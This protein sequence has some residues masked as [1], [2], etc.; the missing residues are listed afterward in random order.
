MVRVIVNANNI[1]IWRRVKVIVSYSFYRL[2][3][4]LQTYFN[5]LH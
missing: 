4:F 2:H 5:I 1:V 3:D